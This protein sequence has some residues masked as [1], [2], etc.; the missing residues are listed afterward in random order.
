MSTAAA[1]WL[2]AERRAAGAAFNGVPAADVPADAV[3]ASASGL[4]PGISVAY[5][6]LLVRRV[7]GD[8]GVPVGDVSALVA[9]ATR[10]RDLGF[11][12]APYVNVLALNLSLDRQLGAG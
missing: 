4:D 5:A 11:I 10:G 6:D 9:E 1:G 12:G 8:R 2:V 3:T 7:A